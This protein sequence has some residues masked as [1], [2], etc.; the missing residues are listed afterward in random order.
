ML[1]KQREIF[2]NSNVFVIKY[3]DNPMLTLKLF[4]LV[5]VGQLLSQDRGII[6]VQRDPYSNL[7][8]AVLVVRQGCSGH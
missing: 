8:Q 2:S 6:R 7:R 3:F 1:E 5:F 4:C